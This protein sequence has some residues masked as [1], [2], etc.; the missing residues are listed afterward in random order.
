MCEFCLRHGEG[1]KWYLRASNYAED[2]LS[3]VR[4][5]RLVTQFFSR[6][7]S[8][9]GP[10]NRLR[11][12]L[13]QRLP[14]FVRRALRARATRR[15]K[16]RHFGQ[17]VPIEE[18]NQ[19]LG[20]VNS[21]VRVSC[22]CRHTKLGRE[23]RYCYGVSMGPGGGKLR[24]LLRGLD[25]SFVGGPDA[26]GL[27]ALTLE[28]ASAA[29]REHEKEGLCHTVWTFMAPF[30]G[31]ICNCDRSDCMA[32]RSTMAGGPKTFFRAEHVA[33]VDPAV[34]DGCRSCMRFCQFG[35]LGYS[36]AA[37]RV[38]V[39]QSACYGCGVCRS[40]CPHDAI[41]LNPRADVPAAANLW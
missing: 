23:E 27:E 5:R 18:V 14:A 19:I 26:S 37:K 29:F 21:V 41:V 38:S 1:K 17:V 24:D 36:A 15:L 16:K 40:G 13:R 30:I 20:I 33:Q 12:R 11:R 4:R 34:C 32:M 3:D 35:A 8:A 6:R 31:G 10:D 2:L 7:Q 9:D 28:Q 39:D 22:V 25:D